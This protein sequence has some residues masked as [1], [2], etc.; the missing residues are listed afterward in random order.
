M[1]VVTSDYAGSKPVVE[2]P[3]P[4]ATE[5]KKTKKSSK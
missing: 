4:A 1:V 2:K 3:A 5:T